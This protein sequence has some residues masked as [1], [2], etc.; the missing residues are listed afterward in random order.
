MLFER[1]ER[2]AILVHGVDPPG[3]QEWLDYV[4]VIRQLDNTNGI[5]VCVLTDGVGPNAV[6]RKMITEFKMRSAVVTSHR[7]A[8][9]MVTALSWIGVAIKAFAPEDMVKALDFLDVP[10]SDHKTLIERMASMRLV[11]DGKD[12]QHTSKL[13]QPELQKIL[14]TPLRARP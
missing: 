3:Q 6:Q 11:L 12:H 4:E 2:W 7:V 5:G 9:G 8:R 10:Q 13:N 1:F 14:N